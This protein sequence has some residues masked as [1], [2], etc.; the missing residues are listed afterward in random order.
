MNSC[1]KR[2]GLRPCR[3]LPI[4]QLPHFGCWALNSEAGWFKGI[5]LVLPLPLPFHLILLLCFSLMRQR[6]TVCADRLHLS[7][8]LGYLKMFLFLQL[9]L[10]SATP[11]PTGSWFGFKK[12]KEKHKSMCFLS[13]KIDI[14]LHFQNE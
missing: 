13:F 4:H 10:V 11:V 7:E 14:T 9:H 2:T 5:C 8:C 3:L 12:G 6:S 1:V